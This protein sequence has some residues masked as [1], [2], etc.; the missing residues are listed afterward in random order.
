M[1]SD[2]PSPWDIEPD[3]RPRNAL[4]PRFGEILT[5]GFTLGLLIVL[6]L[7]LLGTAAGLGVYAY[8]AATLPSPE[9]LYQRASTFQSTKILDR[10][11]K[12]LFEIMDPTAGRRT[13]VDYTDI[14]DVVIEATVATED[15][16]FFTNPGFSPTAIVRSLIEDLRHGDVV[17]GGSTITQQ[18]VKNV[19]LTPEVTF[20]RK[21]KEA[22]LAAEITRRYSKTEIMEIYLNESISATRPTAS[23][24]P[25]RPISKS[26]YR[27][28]TL[29]G[30]GAAGGL[31]AGP[32][33]L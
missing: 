9:D 2:L 29:F 33:L 12:L 19:Y 32:G 16:T 5:R 23:G 25:P 30:S 27:A 17:M 3:K 22:I 10:N 4:R 18:L 14:P 31:S 7:A 28:R 21:I 6:G 13:V 11:G 1:K 26:P 15:S 24:P 20:Q 8:Y